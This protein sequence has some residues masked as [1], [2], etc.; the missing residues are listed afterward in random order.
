M[1][2]HYPTTKSTWY[3]TIATCRGKLAQEAVQ[4]STANAGLIA[5][6]STTSPGFHDTQVKSMQKKLKALH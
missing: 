1:R 6:P 4:H 2:V 5:N 3:D